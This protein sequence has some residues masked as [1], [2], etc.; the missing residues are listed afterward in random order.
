MG[1]QKLPLP[2]CNELK[3]IHAHVSLGNLLS[4]QEHEAIISK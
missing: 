2:V 1:K 3:E 4:L